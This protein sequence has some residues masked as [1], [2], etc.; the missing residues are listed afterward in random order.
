MQFSSQR[1]EPGFPPRWEKKEF[2]DFNGLFKKL[3]MTEL[4]LYHT[5]Q[6]FVN[7]GGGISSGIT[8]ETAELTFFLYS[9][10]R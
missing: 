2:N 10:K 9:L 8:G 7:F 5:E 3:S 4:I 6:G 1:N